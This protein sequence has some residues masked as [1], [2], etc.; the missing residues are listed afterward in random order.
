MKKIFLIVIIL[1]INC[2]L[3][4]SQIENYSV[5]FIISPLS[6]N[7]NTFQLSYETQVDK[8]AAKS[9][10]EGQGAFS[11]DWKDF[12][13][14]GIHS[15]LTLDS[16]SGVYFDFFGRWY[17][18]PKKTNINGWYLQPKI[19]YNI[20]NVGL[21]NSFEKDN[22]NYWTYAY[23]LAFGRKWIIKERFTIDFYLGDKFISKPE[24]KNQTPIANTNTDYLK[25]VNN[26]YSKKEERYLEFR[27]TFGFII[28]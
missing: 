21:V 16:I 18:K 7:I 11:S 14:Y 5:G 3:L 1:F 22:K 13:S 6:K 10:T 25:I 8:Y 23:G 26:M 4:K 17:F 20:F 2:N 27:L 9:K 12:F 24:F 19:G 15:R 28:D